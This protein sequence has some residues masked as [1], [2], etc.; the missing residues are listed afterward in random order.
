MLCNSYASKC[1]CFQRI[2][3]CNSD[4]ECS[5]RCGNP[6]GK[7][8]VKAQ[9]LS[10]EVTEKA[11][12]TRVRRPHVMTQHKISGAEFYKAAENSVIKCPWSTSEDI[13]LTA[14]YQSPMS[15]DG[16]IMCR[17]FNSMVKVIGTEDLHERSSDEI[18]LQ[19]RHI[20]NT[21]SVYNILLSEQSSLMVDQDH[22]IQ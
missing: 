9:S 8:D 18:T 3:G 4:C 7:D 21:D 6:H 2:D 22:E 12:S 5:L 20:S 15:A 19:V 14:V 10:T 16:S 17:L 11:K 13:I 1:P